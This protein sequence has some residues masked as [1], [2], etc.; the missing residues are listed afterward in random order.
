[1]RAIPALFA[2]LL[3]ASAASADSADWAIDA[4]HSHVGFSISHLV[5]SSVNGRF[6]DISGKATLNEADLT[7][8]SVDLTIKVNSLNTDDEKRDAHLKS[9]DFFD[10]AKYPEIKFHSTKI[11][12]G[13]K[14]FKVTGD[15][16]IRDV[17]KS[18]T[19]DGK[20]SKPIKS[21]WGKDVRGAKFEGT[22]KRGDFGLK[23]N[24]ALETGGVV[25]GEDVALDIAVE[26]NK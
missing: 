18:V 14:Q 12:R 15:L 8:S 1:M 26:L 6:K 17:T 20:L 7:K 13:G 24:K 23:W 4:S 9:P 5:V 3:V 22:I 16:T 2:T 19:L 11:A 21:P 10:A 25:V